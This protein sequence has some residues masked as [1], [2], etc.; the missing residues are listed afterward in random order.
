MIKDS[1]QWN[2]FM[3]IN[4]ESFNQEPSDEIVNLNLVI[5]I[6]MKKTDS[7]MN[8]GAGSSAVEHAKHDTNNNDGVKT[9]KKESS[10]QEFF[11]NLFNKSSGDKNNN[12]SAPVTNQYTKVTMDGLMSQLT[13]QNRQLMNQLSQQG[14]S[15]AVNQSD[16][17]K[18]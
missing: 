18:R 1:S 16:T 10:A 6:T 17:N 13:L 15:A 2:R 12:Q 7:Q 3:D 5:K 9:A 14:N 4:I 8:V 11:K